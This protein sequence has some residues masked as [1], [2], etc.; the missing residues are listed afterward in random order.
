VIGD[1]RDH[2]LRAMM[3]KGMLVTINSDDPAY[4]GGYVNENYA[5]VQEALG[6]TQ[7]ELVQLARN[8]FNAAFL[9]EAEKQTLL[10]QVEDYAVARPVYARR[11]G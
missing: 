7:R 1:L 4:F 5:A 11:S 2:P 8:S 9:T 3:E 6:L 10:R